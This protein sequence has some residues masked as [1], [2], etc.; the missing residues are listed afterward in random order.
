MKKPKAY[1]L[2]K[3]GE[4]FD[5]PRKGWRLKCCRCGVVHIIDSFAIK[6]GEKYN[7]ECDPKQYG[8]LICLK[9]DKRF[10]VG[11]ARKSRK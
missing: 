4:W 8:V 7:E 11:D 2:A 9:P 1:R 10:Y 6:Y 3:P 5:L